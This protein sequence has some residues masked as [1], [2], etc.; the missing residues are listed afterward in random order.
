MMRVLEETLGGELGPVEVPVRHLH[1]ADAD[2][3]DLPVL[4]LNRGV[5]LM[6]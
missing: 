2:F 5:V 6:S 3:T 4:E 1:S